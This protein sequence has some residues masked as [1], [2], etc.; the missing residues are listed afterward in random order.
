M[1][2]ADF[3]PMDDDRKGGNPDFDHPIDRSGTQHRTPEVQKYGRP[4][5]IEVAP[6]GVVKYARRGEESARQRILI[7]SAT[8]QFTPEICPRNYPLPE[9]ILNHSS[10]RHRRGK[11][12]FP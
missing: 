2:R 7:D 6:V 8:C 5:G 12:G 9:A 11:K 1:R 4:S 10:S 3:W